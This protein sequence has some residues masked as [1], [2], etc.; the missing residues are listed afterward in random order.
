MN[1]SKRIEKKS[2]TQIG[3]QFTSDMDSDKCHM[4]ALLFLGESRMGAGGG[5]R[6]RERETEGS[7]QYL[8]GLQIFI[9]S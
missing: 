2:Q 4:G 8:D 5:E 1:K 9:I 3:L 7:L 6:E